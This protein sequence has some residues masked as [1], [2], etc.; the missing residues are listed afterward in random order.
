MRK[1]FPF[2]LKKARHIPI[3]SN[4]KPSS[5]V[6]GDF[7]SLRKKYSVKPDELI[8][9]YFGMVYPGKGMRMLLKTAKI[10]NRKLEL[11]FKLFIIGGG[12]SDVPE[13]IQER[14]NLVSTLGIPDK[15]VF[16]GRIDSTEVAGLLSASALV[17]LPFASG[18][19]DRRGTLMAA[20]ACNK[21]IVTTRPDLDIDLF[22]NGENMIWPDHV[23]AENLA[24]TTKRVIEDPALRQKLERGAGDLAQN[25]RWDNIAR[26]T[27]EF[28]KE[29]VS[30][31]AFSSPLSAT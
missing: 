15:I 19:S 12:I 1:Y 10:L 7:I 26:Q 29:L 27:R 3:G 2:F 28:Y 18:A 16:T 6:N 13:Y 25:Y 30:D 31:S 11:D 23:C 9:A 22:R 8:I 21:A 4:I 24:E 14:K 20:L 17:I 5:V